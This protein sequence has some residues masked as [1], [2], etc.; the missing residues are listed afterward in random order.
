MI[1][2]DANVVAGVA[3]AGPGSALLERVLGKDDDWVCPPLWRSEYLNVL[4]GYL[5]L[6][7]WTIE[8]AVDAF[9]RALLL[10]RAEA[11]AD[12]AAILSLVA[13][14]SCTAYDLE[15]VALARELAIPLVTLDRQV[16]GFF[17]TI[18]QSPAA[19][20]P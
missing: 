14:S 18:A 13:A 2:V 8:E 20:A 9:D 3:I 11:S 5:R 15:Y 10:V 16:L 1:V 19:F 7:A 4:A 12:P 6:R 17:P